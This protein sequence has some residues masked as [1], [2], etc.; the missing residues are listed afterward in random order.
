MIAAGHTPI[1]VHTEGAGSCVLAI[2]DRIR[3]G[4]AGSIASLKELGWDLRVCSG[5]DERVVSRIASEAGIETAE[6]G[7]SPEGKARLV[8]SLK[9]EQPKRSV[10]MVGDGVND[11]AALA[12]ADVGIAV[13]GGAEASLE[14]ADVF[15][16]DMGVFPL[17]RL[18]N[19]GSST[20]RTIRLCLV[21]SIAYNAIAATLAMTGVINALMAAV[22]MPIS[23]LSV[24]ALCIR[25]LREDA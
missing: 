10:V 13:H 25:S 12:S 21:I 2:G 23:S 7:V 17:V 1:G 18:V 3:P 4:V 14:A 5:D 19:L 9:Q 11:T 15:L 20:M 22:L 16:S 8:A 24:V 6:G